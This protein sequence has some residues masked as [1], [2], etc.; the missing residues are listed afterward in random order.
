MNRWA[1]SLGVVGA[2]LA[3]GG[4]IAYTLAPDKL[5]LVTLC[6]GL[7]LVCLVVFFVARFEALKAFSIRRST[8]LGANS[9]LMVLLFTAI[10]VIV[11]FL[12]ARHTMRWDLSET[13]HF[14]LA[15]Q[16]HKILRGLTREVKVTVFAQERSPSYNT[17]R[18]LL[19]SYKQDS[20]KL[21]VEF[22]DP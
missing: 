5:W 13:Q 15:P 11:N 7:A 10:L 21:K 9:I 3:A 1:S 17:Y 14:T 4:F 20:D 2:G 8:R 22:V 6:E 19:D 18:D 12:A 16:T